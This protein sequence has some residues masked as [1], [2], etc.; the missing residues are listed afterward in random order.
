MTSVNIIVFLQSEIQIFMLTYL[1]IGTNLGDRTANV[2]RALA[3]INE[4][5]GTVVRRSSD[6]V[7][8]PWGFVSANMFLNIVVAVETEQ[9]PPELL[10]STQRIERIMGRTHKSVGGHYADRIID[11]DILLYGDEVINLPELKIP[12][13]HIEERDFVRIPLREIMG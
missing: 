13:P 6:F 5:V 2:E 8:K 12:H 10:A 3:L 9:L 1:S 11:I 7:S 4:Q